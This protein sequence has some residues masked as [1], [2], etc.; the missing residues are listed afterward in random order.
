VKLGILSR[1][2]H[3]L[4][5]PGGLERAV[6][7][8]AKHLAAR[9]L[10]ITLVT[11]PPTRA[12]SFPGSVRIVPYGGL[13]LGPHGSVAD[14]LVHYPLFAMRCGAAAAELVRGGGADA[15]VAH[16]ITAWGIGRLRASDAKL[17]VPLVMNP[18]G[19]EEHKARGIKGLALTPLKHLSRVSARLADRVIATDSS[20]SA[21][22]HSLLGVSPE[23]IV[24]VPNGVDLDEIREATPDE[25][26]AEVE[27]MLP[28][29]RGAA[30]LLLSVGRLEAY[31]GFG[32]LL[33]A[34][35]QLDACGALPARWAWVVVGGGPLAST[36]D[37]LAET[38]LAGHVV[39]TGRVPDALLHAL[40]A[41]S[42]LFL[43]ATRYEGSSLV[44]LEA[45]AHSLPVVATKAGG[46]PDKVVD[47]VTGLL[48]APGDVAG[49]AEAIGALARDAERRRAMG[50]A[51][52]K[53]VRER[54]A[55]PAIA[56]TMCGVLEG[57]LRERA[58]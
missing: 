45:M 38:P 54:Y 5:E 49:V 40:Y 14:R 29:L 58:S 19:L 39:R 56:E 31:K 2:A 42:D 10:R 9:G 48:V 26:R 22:I 43:H 8:S 57:L 25:P 13:P 7:H 16:G 41:V 46:I 52:L 12:G 37:R 6:Y 36:F 33:K 3:P 17:R 28:G 15:V 21:D 1:S 18:H 55:W 27:R 34:L 51:G 47:G 44:T 24:L 53:L 11:R 20:L 23:R 4:H 30:P 50:T 32:D 35:R